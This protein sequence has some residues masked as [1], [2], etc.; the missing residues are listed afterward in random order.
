MVL[1]IVT[2][3]YCFKNEF[4]YLVDASRVFMTHTDAID[5]VNSLKRFR[6]IGKVV[7]EL[8]SGR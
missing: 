4:G 8:G 3:R 6:L 7:L 1:S 2:V 5:F